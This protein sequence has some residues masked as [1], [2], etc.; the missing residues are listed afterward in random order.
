MNKLPAFLIST[1]RA[2][3]SG[4]LV[5]AAGLLMFATFSSGAPT[6]SGIDSGGAELKSGLQISITGAGF[7]S[8]DQSAPVLYDQT[9]VTWENGVVNKYQSTF[10][11]MTLV[12]R[13]TVDPNTIWTKPSVPEEHSS[14]MLVTNSRQT[15]D[16]ELGSHYYGKGN[17][18]FLGWP[19]A[20]GGERTAYQSSKMYSAFWIK[21]PYDLTNYY[22][23]PAEKNPSSFI[24]GGSESYGEEIKI[25]GVDGLGKVIAYE[26]VGKVPNGWLFIEPPRGVSIKELTGKRVVGLDS[27][28]EVVFPESSSLSKFDQSGFLSP[29]GKYARFWS[30]PS[31][32]GYRFSLANLGLAGTGKSIWANA[33]GSRSPEPG[34]WNL[35]EIEI[36]L[37]SN[38]SLTAWLNG[39]VYLA[40]DNEWTEALKSSSVDDT[41]GLTIALLGIDDFMPVPFT[42]ELDDIYL[43][44]SLHRVLLCNLPTIE[45][46]RSKGAHCE[47]QRP[48]AWKEREISI[49]LKLGTLSQHK[50]SVYLYVFD[51]KG[52]VNAR[53]W[54]LNKVNAPLPPQDFQAQ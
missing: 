51:S 34:T 33:F 14:G 11:D 35:F 36:D 16:G 31:G 3:R 15:R 28:S 4:R 54:E 5:S 18:N 41:T 47:V 22:A 37:G 38:P 2:T 19:K 23:I 6:L 9:D 40:S 53:G 39:R 32:T 25:E 46:V 10:E 48:V 21:L 8:K 42:V 13:V 43:D 27:G 30:D 44:K 12:K 52:D 1:G 17:V 45:E 29:R 26:K 24:T 50:D 20:S 7:G 49:E